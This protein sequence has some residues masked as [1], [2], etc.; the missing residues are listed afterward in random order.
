MK[1]SDII[2]KPYKNN[3]RGPN[4]F[5]CFGVVRY[6]YKNIL[7]IELPEYTDYDEK[8]YDNS[9]VLTEQLNRFSRLWFPVKIP[10]KW[11][12]LTFSHGAPKGI[13]NHCS[14]YLGDGK[15]IHCYERS[16]VVI[17]RLTRPYWTRNLTGI[18]RYKKCQ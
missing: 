6:I 13:T 14:V 18:M 8:W 9:N 3:G 15:M 16:P 5:D 2:G 11:D 1:L 17:D 7:D 12:V 10:E 4:S